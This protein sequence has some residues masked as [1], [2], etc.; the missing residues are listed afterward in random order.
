MQE[1]ESLLN[2]L[3]EK[4]IGGAVVRLDGVPVASTIG[5]RD[6]DIGL[7]A[8]VSNVADALMKGEG[9]KQ[10]EIEI[11]FGGLIVVIVPI[12]DHIF[13]GMIKDRSE[14]DIILEYAQKAKQFL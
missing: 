4:G 1:L 14:K 13:C 10:S 5:M 7:F 3:K 12:K 6:V 2:E 9:D 11:S 8:S